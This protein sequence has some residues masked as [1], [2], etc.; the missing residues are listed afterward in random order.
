MT[1]QQVRLSFDLSGFSPLSKENSLPSV[2]R[3]SVQ[4]S[5][6]LPGKQ[7][8]LHSQVDDF[9]QVS[10]F[11][12]IP[13]I[14]SNIGILKSGTKLLRYSTCIIPNCLELLTN[15]LEHIYCN[16]SHGPGTSRYF[17]VTSQAKSKV[18]SKMER[19]VEI[20]DKYLQ[21]D[22]AANVWEQSSKSSWQL[23]IQLNKGDMP[24]LRQQQAAD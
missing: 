14:N 23:E 10:H 20:G 2:Q 5:A 1:Q 15:C 17:L 4:S 21:V 13:L 11:R 22:V 7:K 24:R 6:R 12:V 8:H 9:H 16:R 19:R 3:V 18:P